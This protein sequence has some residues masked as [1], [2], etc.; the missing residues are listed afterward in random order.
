MWMRFAAAMII[1]QSLIAAPAIAAEIPTSISYKVFRNGSEIGHHRLSFSRE[2]ENMVVDVNIRLRVGL[3]R[4]VTFFLYEHDSR[5]IWREGRLTSITSR[6][7]NDG[8]RQR[9]Q[10]TASGPAFV[11]DGSEKKGQ[12]PA[13]PV[14]TSYWNASLLNQG[15][16]LDSQNGR[17]LSVKVSQAGEERL[18]IGN[19]TITA[20][21]YKIEG[22]LE[23]EIWYDA[24]GRWV[25]SQFRAHDGSLIDYQLMPDSLRAA[26][27]AP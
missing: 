10:A 12:M 14:P 13:P 11:I 2:G 5:E 7:N 1:L 21:R 27:I 8:E 9:L 25:K 20:K 17:L 6:T 26:A 24:N 15:F 18:T 4:M 3:G 16:L 23:K 22:E 19:Q